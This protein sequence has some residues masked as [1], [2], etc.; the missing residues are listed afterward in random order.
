MEITKLVRK[1]TFDGVTLDDPSPVMTPEQV[2]NVF[3][4]SYPNILNAVIEGPVAKN[5][6]L[7]YTFKRNVGT[8]A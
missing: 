8:K 3:A 6:T 1:F 7:V 4:L 2:K 5:D